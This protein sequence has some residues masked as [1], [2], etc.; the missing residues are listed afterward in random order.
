MRHFLFERYN[1]MVSFKYIIM[2]DLSV[3][4][5]NVSKSAGQSVKSIYII[6]ANI[7]QCSGKWFYMRIAPTQEQIPEYITN[8]KSTT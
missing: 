8:G 6:F 1:S 5:S 7:R 4:E 2:V 3:E